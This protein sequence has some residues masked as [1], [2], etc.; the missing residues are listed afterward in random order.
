LKLDLANFFPSI[1]SIH[2]RDGLRRLLPRLPQY[3]IEW[4]V[5]L[6]TFEGFLPAG[7]PTSPTISNII[8]YDFDKFANSING[9]KYSRYGD[10]LTFSAI[11]G[12][13]NLKQV[14]RDVK[15]ELEKW[16]FQIQEAKTFF[17][18]KGQRLRITGVVLNEKLNISREYLKWLRA[19]VYSC[20]SIGI[21]KA[22]TKYG[23]RYFEKM[24]NS[25]RKKYRYIGVYVDKG[26]IKKCITNKELVSF[27]KASLLGHI[28]YVSSVRGKDDVYVQNLRNRFINCLR[29]EGLEKKEIEFEAKSFKENENLVYITNAT[30]Q[31]VV[32]Y[33]YVFLKSAKLSDDDI[34]RL[35]KHFSYKDSSNI[36]FKKI[37]E[38]F[39]NQSIYFLELYN[40]MFYRDR[41]KLFYESLSDDEWN[42]L[43]NRDQNFANK[44]TYPR[45]I[46][47]LDFNCSNIR[48]NY[49]EEG[50]F[51]PNSGVFFEE[52][53]ANQVYN[54]YLLEKNFLDQLGMRTCLICQSNISEFT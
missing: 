42:Q 16:Q 9:I 43:F 29:E 48:N 44:R 34:N 1:K 4:L 32:Y 10:D 31:S 12:R 28:S 45:W 40:Y 18:R 17:L 46:Y 37:K 30:S 20:E 51:H 15:I 41:F 6:T 49:N 35:R 54:A 53:K 47:H 2:V 11:D 3:C 21:E 27:L 39:I 13:I 24:L 7:A 8:L 14:E 19:V 26:L 25:T 5:H 38:N 50:V 22:A 23:D 33:A 36:D 52:E